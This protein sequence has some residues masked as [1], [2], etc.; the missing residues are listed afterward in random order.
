MIEKLK[1]CPKCGTSFPSFGVTYYDHRLFSRYHI[2]CWMCRYRGKPKI[3]MKR[4]IKAWN[5]IRR[6]DNG[7]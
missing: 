7:K 5:K 2:E 1:P 4:A 3:G 6:T